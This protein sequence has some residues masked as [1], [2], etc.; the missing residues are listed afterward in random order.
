MNTFA[1]PETL[2]HK[3]RSYTLTPL[4]LEVCDA[5][6]TI[7]QGEVG[8]CGGKSK[9]SVGRYFLQIVDEDPSFAHVGT[10]FLILKAGTRDVYC[11]TVA[12]RESAGKCTCD[13]FRFHGHCKHL[14]AL[15]HAVNTAGLLPGKVD[16][17]FTSDF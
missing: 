6:L 8:P 12:P 17:V 1:L 9:V 10:E 2:T 4:A 14:A 16:A 5:L 13:G 3:V 15:T 11:V 7:R